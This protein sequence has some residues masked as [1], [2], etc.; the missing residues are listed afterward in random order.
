MP[1]LSLGVTVRETVRDVDRLAN[2]RSRASALPP[3]FQYLVAEV[4]L[5]RL[6]A[7][8]ESAIEDLA[9][10]LVAGAPY[11]NGSYPSPIHGARSIEGAHQAMCTYGRTKAKRYLSWNS[12]SAIRDNVSKVL[13]DAEPFVFR[14]RAHGDLLDEVRIVRNRVAHSSSKAR[15][16]FREVVR[17]TYGANVSLSVG[18]FLTSTTRRAVAKIDQYLG[19]VRI[20]VGE[21]AAGN[22]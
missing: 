11:T 2:Y 4:V 8:T 9:C 1:A 21:M 18:M 14:A 17:A 22:Q 19:D 20:L 16:E 12:A 15:G 7:I 13:S 3:E 5:L 6:T 10:K